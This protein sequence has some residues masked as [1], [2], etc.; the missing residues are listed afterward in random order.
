MQRSRLIVLV[1]GPPLIVLASRAL[2]EWWRPGGSGE[3][4]GNHVLNAAEPLPRGAAT[5]EV[6][7]EKARV[8]AEVLAKR[9]QYTA[10]ALRARLGDDCSLIVRSPFVVAGDMTEKQLQ[11]WYDQTIAPAAR[12]MAYSYFKKPPTEP[13]TVLLFSKEEPYD[14]YAKKLFND[15]KVSVYGYYK[16]DKKTL[17]M[18][19]DTG[20]G[21]LVHELTH[22]LIVYDFPDVPDW[23]NEGLASLHEQCRFRPAG[24]G[25]E[26]L[27]NWRLPGLKSAIKA[28]RLGSLETLM[29]D[30]DFRGAD[31]G[32]NYAQARYFCLYLQ[33]KNLLVRFYERFRARHQDDPQGVATARAV[34]GDQEWSKID[35]E[36]RDWA[37]GLE[38]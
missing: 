22:A 6:A 12:A 35:A 9:S 34:L 13:I 24:Q 3:F 10:D 18:N 28:N 23:F 4:R 27:V 33:E 7:A 32:V 11:T 15:E 29:N 21:T 19:I 17:V 20:G 36:F 16:P 1:V 26:G 5:D 30:D 14:H 25:L 38:L 37:M 31:I 2:T 8:E